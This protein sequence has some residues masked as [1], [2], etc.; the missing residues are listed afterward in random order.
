MSP[1]ESEERIA[2]LRQLG[3]S[4]REAGFLLLAALHSGAFVMRQYEAFAGVKRGYAM[5]QLVAKATRQQ[6]VRTYPSKNRSLIYQICEPIFDAVGD[7]DNRNFQLKQPDITRLRLMSLD[8]VLAH[9]DRTYHATEAEKLAFFSSLAVVPVLLPSQA[10][11]S[12]LGHPPTTHYFI[13]RT[14][15]YT[16]GVGAGFAFMCSLS[17]QTFDTFLERY[18]PLMKALPETELTYV[19]T[20]PGMIDAARQSFIKKIDSHGSIDVLDL[21]GEFRERLEL[22]DHFAKVGPAGIAM[23]PLRKLRQHRHSLNAKMYSTWKEQGL[24]SL[25]N[26]LS[27]AEADKRLAFTSCLLPDLYQ[28][29]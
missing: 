7:V 9:Q 4:E 3:Y 15:I 16:R 20:E 27:P 11:Q 28:L 6:H 19:S 23:E 22:E 5:N 21:E 24:A 12:N 25:A 26:R 1:R 14:P 17:I 13:E 10:Y 8:F 18:L 29:L 2:R